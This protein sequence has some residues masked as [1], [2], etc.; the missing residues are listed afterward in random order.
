MQVSTKQ[1]SKTQTVITVTATPGEISTF[2]ES[3]LKKLRKR[4]KVAGF[5]EGKVPLSLVEKNVDQAVLQSEFLEE[6]VSSLY[7]GA[8]RQEKIRPVDR[9]EV[10]ISKFVPFDTLEF[11]AT[12]PS[13]NNIKIPE[14]K[15]IKKPKPVAKVTAD[16]V[17]E[18]LQSLP[19]RMAEKKDVNRKSKDGDQIWIDFNGVDAEGNPVNGADGKDYPLALGSKTFIPGFE[20]NLIGL[21][22]GD[23]KT[24]TLKFPKDYSVEALASRK[25]TFTVKVTKVQEV[26]EPKLDDEFAKQ[27]GPFDSLKSLKEDI[28]KQLG[29]ERQREVERK[30]ESEIVSEISQKT[31][32]SIPQVL[33]D[34]QVESLVRETRQNLNYQGQTWEEFLAAEGKTEDEY[35]KTVLAPEAEKRVRASIV[36]SEIAEIENLEVTLEELEIRMQLL[37][38]QYKD[39]SMQQ[40]LN[41]PE[42]RRDIAS[43][44]LTEKTVAKLVHYA[45]T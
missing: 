26:V 27:V 21:S 6:A 29:Y 35:R 36:L 25:V 10:K 33:I 3:V 22:A 9:P 42:A 23:E 18:V 40:E 45:T 4:V 15:K 43:R 24:F 31:N 41:K 28:K 2:K 19:K 1:P 32:F 39:N 16:E 30:L 13:I 7:A 20:E 14:Y 37:K 5:R 44:L 38:N 11:E 8:V 17:N 12:V 34:D